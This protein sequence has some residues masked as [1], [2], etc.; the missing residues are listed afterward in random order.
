MN[1]FSIGVSEG[2][3]IKQ[4]IFPSAAI[5][6]TISLSKLLDKTFIFIKDLVFPKRYISKLSPIP[7]E[8]MAK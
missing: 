4:N 2:V 7:L 1:Y 3:F 8:K 6:V 5:R